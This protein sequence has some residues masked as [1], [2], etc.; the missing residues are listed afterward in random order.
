[1]P[2]EDLEPGRLAPLQE[3]AC[4][5]AVSAP[6]VD[7]RSRRI[8]PWLVG[9]GF[10]MQL[11]DGT[12]LNT[13]LPNMARDL[14]ESPLRMQSVVLAYMI[15]VALLIPASGWL[16]DRWGTRRV[17]VGAI[18]LFTLGSLLCALSPTLPLLVA[19]RVVQG[20]GGALLLPVGR[21]AILR[22]FSGDEQIEVLSFVSIPAL[23]GPLI[24]PTL[25]GWLVEWASWH[26]VFLINLP[27]G[28]IG[29]LVAGRYMVNVQRP[30]QRFDSRGFALFA[31]GLVLMSLALQGLGERALSTAVSIVMVVAG[32]AA[33]LAYWLHA[34]RVPRP[35]FATSL[36][37][38]PVYAIGLAG[39]LFSRLGSGAMPF[40]VPLYLQVALGYSPSA[41]GMSM[42]PS[43]LG[44]MASKP[45]APWLIRTLGYRRLLTAN[46]LLLGAVI[47]AFALSDLQTTPVQL[48][49]LMAVFGLINSTQFTAMNTLTLGALDDEHA[50][51]GNSLLLV[52][53]QLSMSLGVAAGAGVLLAFSGA[54][55]SMPTG[56]AVP[57][58]APVQ[59]VLQHAFHASFVCVGGLSMLAAL[60]FVQL[61]PREAE[62]QPHP[63]DLG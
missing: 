35:L 12:I 2:A 10:F 32:L 4:A 26:W 51:S 48:L 31:L 8:L 56:G 62:T 43:A 58:A 61:H 42:I 17:F 15:T 14:N 52:V 13:A 22:V 53:V 40:L 18:G 50:S 6:V 5:E 3:A 44:A 38:I 34:S 30:S 41:A 25:G 7:P 60:I 20:M 27:V 54:H 47:L 49:V 11:L 23:L 21:L 9:A 24:G 33:M 1:M 29:M 57:L 37:R 16:A 59:A 63:G 19:A 39:N 46:T 55:G 28:L 36:L 45:F